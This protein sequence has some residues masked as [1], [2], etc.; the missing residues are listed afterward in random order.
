MATVYATHGA[1]AVKQIDIITVANAWTA[2]DTATM[3]I[4]GKDL[5]V[6]IGADTSTTQVAEALRDAWNATSRLDSEGTTDATSNFGGQ[7]FGEYSEATASIDPDSPSVVIITANKAGVPFTLTVTENTAST[8]TATQATSQAATGPWH[9]DNGDNWS[10]GTAPANDDVVVLKDCSGPNVGFKYGLPDNSSYPR[11]VTIQHW[12]SYTGEIGLPPINTSSPTKPFPEYRA[13]FVLLNDAGTGTTIAHTFGLGQDGTGSPMINLRHDTLKV[14]AIVYNTGTP[15]ISGRKALN[16]VCTTNTSTVNVV[17]GSVDLSSQYS[18]TAAVVTLSQ[19]GGDVRCIGG[20][21]ASSTVTC[22]GGKAVIG[23]S[24]A[25]DTMTV[26]G[27]Q[28]KLEGQTGTITTLRIQDGGTVNASSSA[29]TF[30]TIA[31]YNGGT[32]DA[33]ENAGA[34]TVTNSSLQRGGKWLDPYRRCTLSN[35]MTISYDPSPELVFGANLA[36]PVGITN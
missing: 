5:V 18:G 16:L 32:F 21:K 26:T 14:A 36:N 30:T 29:L 1:A 3:T 2:A 27:G 23:G 4:N 28:V 6:T 33:R 17:N 12:M 10:G 9:W 24:T 8:G 25:I 20:L 35:A 7:E 22:G 11:E 19:T 15:Q 34:L 13:Q 31:V